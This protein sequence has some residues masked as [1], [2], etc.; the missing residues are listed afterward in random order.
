MIKRSLYCKLIICLLLFNSCGHGRTKSWAEGLPIAVDTISYTTLGSL[1][2][3]VLTIRDSV[4]LNNRLC[5]IPDGITLCFN[6]GTVNNGTLV[7]NMTKIKCK[8]ACLNRVGILG[9]WNVPIIR[10]SYFCDLNYDNALKDVVAL[11]HPSV[12]N[13]II[14]DKG[15]YQVSAY[16]NGDECIPICSNTELVMNGNILLT[17][18]D[19][20]NYY[21]I[22]LS[23]SN[24][25]VKG[26]GTIVGDKHDHTGNSGEWGMG[27]NLDDAHH[28]TISGLTIKDCWGDCIYVGSESSDVIIEK[29]TLDHGRRQ[30]ISITSAD[31][32][33]IKNCLITNVKGL[34]RNMQLM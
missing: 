31:S 3:G 28:V 33:T 2:N 11:S 13:K 22:Q 1:A 15:N 21:I 25:S 17:P 12:K 4:D 26:K 30:G 18:N 19:Y 7:G 32:V 10:S 5:N 6:G 29:C 24:I 8:K 9:T 16:K 34:I 14:I 23:G 20:R 27:I